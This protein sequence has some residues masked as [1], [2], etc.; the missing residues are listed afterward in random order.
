MGK[1]RK[2]KI[3]VGGTLLEL[4]DLDISK[5]T[6]ILVGEIHTHIAVQ[7][8]YNNI[9]R[10]QK[11]IIDRV[12]AKFGKNKTY[13]YSEAPCAFQQQVLETEIYSACVVVQ[14]ANSKMPIKLSNICNEREEKGM[15]D[16]EYADD[17]LSIFDKNVEVDC[18]I[19]Q[20]GL[21]HIL[22]LKKHIEK[23]PD[24]NIIIINTAS[25]DQ[26]TRLRHVL[27]TTWEGFEL[28]EIEKYYDLPEEETFN[29]SSK[30][31]KEGGIT[32]NGGKRNRRTN[33]KKSK[34]RKC[35]KTRHKKNKKTI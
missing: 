10:K 6:I 34:S 9:I 14:Y 33:R 3:M 30:I 11:D 35:I 23:R 5:K 1:N 26:I 15:C 31:P 2:N 8:Q 32:R 29:F 24:I 20:I 19:V 7:P 21:A 28:L 13:F 16:S 27:T 4:K 25:Q 18:I 12:N 17:I 22:E